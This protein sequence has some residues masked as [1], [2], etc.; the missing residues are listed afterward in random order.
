MESGVSLT[1]M[2]P[3]TTQKYSTEIQDMY[4]RRVFKLLIEN[5]GFLEET[6]EYIITTDMTEDV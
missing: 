3:V 4:G 6:K 1:Y 2:L 5:R